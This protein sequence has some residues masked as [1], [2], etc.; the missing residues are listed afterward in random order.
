MDPQIVERYSDYDGFAWIYNLHWG[1]TEGG[2]ALPRL[3]RL[4][5]GDIQPSAQIL[6]LCC[7]SGHLAQTLIDEGYDVTGIDG[8]KELLKFA[9]ENAPKANFILSDARL[10]DLAP[11]YDAVVSISDSLNHVMNLSE[12]QSVFKRVYSALQPGGIFHFDLNMK[13]KFTS[14]WKGSF[15]IVEDDHVCAVIS[16]YKPQKEIADFRA[17]IFEK[18][19]RG[20]ERSDVTLYQRWYSISDI[21]DSLIKVGFSDIE[22]RNPKLE[23][24]RDDNVDKAFFVCKKREQ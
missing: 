11:E 4:F 24:Y 6:D 5:L 2:K 15:A 20:W 9:Q 16:D 23:V 14:S 13:H 12:L 8:S 17:T 22:I 18:T 3:R 10:F 21:T 1:P 7:G 19:D